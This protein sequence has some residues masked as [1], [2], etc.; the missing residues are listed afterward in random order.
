MVVSRPLNVLHT[1]GFPQNEHPKR[2]EVEA[3]LLPY[4]IGQISHRAIL[5]SREVEK[6]ISSLDEGV[7]KC[8]CRRACGM[9]DIIETMFGKH[10]KSCG[11]RQRNE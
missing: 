3:S 7:A 10:K 11:R 4:Y 2:Q 6:Y 1:T 8:H 9:E 5:A